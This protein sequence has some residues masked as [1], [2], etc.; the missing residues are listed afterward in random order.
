M[1]GF[2]GYGISCTVYTVKA[3]LF[4]ICI[5]CNSRSFGCYPAVEAGL[6]CQLTFSAWL[7]DID[8]LTG[9]WYPY[10][11]YSGWF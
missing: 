6:L 8:T 9:E 2:E 11:I 3:D 1:Q 5:F 4:S 10:K 7:E